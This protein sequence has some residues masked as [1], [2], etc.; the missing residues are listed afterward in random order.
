MAAI[1]VGMA[2]VSAC[3]IGPN[4]PENI[5]KGEEIGLFHHGGCTHCLLF[6][7]GVNLSWVSAG[8]SKRNTPLRSELAYVYQ[9]KCSFIQRKEM[10][11]VSLTDCVKK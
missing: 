2:D 4:L 7:P 11:L 1:Y 10:G 6:R 8:V 3:E 5:Q 9:W